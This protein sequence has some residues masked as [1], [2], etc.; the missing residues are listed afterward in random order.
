MTKSNGFDCS[1]HQEPCSKY[2]EGFSFINIQFWDLC[3]SLDGI[4][5]QKQLDAKTKN[6][7]KEV[8]VDNGWSIMK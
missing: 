6:E 8:N 7:E 4:S 3:V 2:L 5:G 1:I